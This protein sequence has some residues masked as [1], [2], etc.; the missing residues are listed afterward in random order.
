MLRASVVSREVSVLDYA[1][2]IINCVTPDFG[3]LRLNLVE[4][5]VYAGDAGYLGN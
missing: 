1:R 5:K 3:K 2:T 4:L